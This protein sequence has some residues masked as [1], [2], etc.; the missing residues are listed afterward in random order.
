MTNYVHN[1]F[2]KL[3]IIITECGT[4]VPNEPNMSIPLIKNDTFRQK[5]FMDHIKALKESINIDKVPIKAFI[6]WALFDNFEWNTYDQRFGLIAIEGIGSNNGTLNRI[7]KDS[8]QYISNQ[9][10][11]SKSPF[12][13]SKFY[14]NNTKRNS[15]VSRYS[16]DLKY[17]SILLSLLIFG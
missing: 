8:F 5:F 11:K 2:P 9:L 4:S 15:V 3:D 1:A 14:G 10:S 12:T 6:S 16:Q 13:V 7:T 17:T